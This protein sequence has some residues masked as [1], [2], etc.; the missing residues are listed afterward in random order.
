MNERSFDPCELFSSQSQLVTM[1]LNQIGTLKLELIV[2]WIPLLCTK[3]ARSMSSLNSSQLSGSISKPKENASGSTST[4][5]MSSNDRRPRIL[6]REKKRGNATTR[7]KEVWR[8]STNILDSV[9]NDISRSI[10]S[11]DANGK[12]EVNGL[13]PWNRSQSIAQLGPSSSGDSLH[14]SIPALTTLPEPLAMIESMK[15]YLPKLIRRC[16]ELNLFQMCLNSWQALLKRSR[17][18]SLMTGGDHCESVLRNSRSRTDPSIR[19]SLCA[20]ASYSPPFHD[21]FD[22]SLLMHAHEQKYVDFQMNSICFLF[23]V[24]R[25]NVIQVICT[26]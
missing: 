22:D 21:E 18:L 20:T 3:T 19:S 10:P 26:A 25:S 2:T 1:N 14:S 9:Y 5:D 8:S 17:S 11:I 13:N 7:Q 16:P 15:P 12:S 4:S 23:E 24:F 6:L